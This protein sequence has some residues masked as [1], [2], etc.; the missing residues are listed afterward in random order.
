[1]KIELKHVDFSYDNKNQV[2][3]DISLTI[4]SNESVAVIG[5]N[6]AGKTTLV[7]Q[8]NG[9][10][11]PTGGDILLDGK[12]I[13][14]SSVAELA[15]QVGYVFQNPDDQL[16]LTTVLKELEFGPKQLKIAPDKR[17]E[18]IKKAAGL[19]GL[20]ELLD[21]HPLDLG[22][23]KKKFCTIASVLSMNTDVVIFDEPTMGQDIRGI[24]RLS[25][26]IKELKRS[27]KICITITHDMKFAARN[28]D[29]MIV[30]MQG[31]VL[32]DDK[33]KAVFSKPEVL[34]RSYITP[35]PI[36]RVCQKC[37]IGDCVFT[38]DEF[39]EEMIK[40]V[41]TDSSRS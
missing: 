13:I 17:E 41:R 4:E 19:C 8:L 9:I 22:P 14:T 2:L 36:T 11:K 26:I 3:K 5:Q 12:S 27:G 23:A 38:I 20:T 25:D 32:L 31:K 35:P 21:A 6:G 28:F 7:K 15:K 39:Q 37:G 29:R 24:K 1:M 34:S 16:F 40:K 30:L 33:T 10:L 18:C